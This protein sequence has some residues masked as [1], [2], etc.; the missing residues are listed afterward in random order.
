MVPSKQL[1]LSKRL[2]TEDGISDGG[3]LVNENGVIE[4]LLTTE[5]ANE[6]IS[7]SSGKITVVDGGALA[8]LAGVVDSHVH[9]NEPGR[10]AWEGF[11]T[12]TNAA[13]AGATLKM[14]H[15]RNS[16]PPTTT[17]ENLKTKASA[18]KE[19]IF[20]DVGFW[21]GFPNV[22]REDLEKAFSALEGT[23]SLLAKLKVINRC[24]FSDPEEYSTYLESR[25]PKME[26][27]AISL[28]TSLLEKTD[29][30]GLDL[31]SIS[32]YLSSGPANLC[33]LQHKKGAIKPGVD[34]D[35]VF[36]DSDAYFTL[37]PYI[38]RKLKGVVKKTYL[39]GQLIFD[40]EVVGEPKGELIL[41][42][43]R[44]VTLSGEFEGGVMVDE[45]GVIEAVLSKESVKG[46][47][48]ETLFNF[49]IIDGGNLAL[50]AGVVDSHVHVN[51]PGRTSW[52]GYVTATEAAAAG[53]ITTIIDMPFVHVHIVHVSAEGVVPILERAREKRI[54]AGYIGWRGGITAETCN[55]Y[56]TL[57]SEYIP[58]GHTE[59]KCS[60][61]IRDNANKEKLWQY[62]KEQ[63]LDLIT[64]DHSPSM[65]SLKGVNFL[66]AWG[67]ISS[68]QFDI[69]LFWTEAKARG[70]SLSSVS[71]YLSA[72]PAQL[73]GLQEKK[74]AIRPGLDADLIFFDPDTSFVVTPEIIRYKNKI[75]P[76]MH[77][78]L[79]GKVKQT[80]LRGQLVFADG[81]LIGKPK[82]QLLLSED[83]ID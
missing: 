8:L 66:E 79:N 42:H 64:S 11:R 75:S 15:Y 56:L 29:H 16:I 80:Y 7:D 17:L 58:P 43:L 31:R 52:E 60:P 32:K 51:E 76:Y 6:L 83:I 39:R 5:Q 1:F 72:G 19:N 69:S 35:L 13:A 81:D 63:R 62:I 82:G 73:C 38:G 49:Q 61:P 68:L 23:G 55:H 33:G 27:K 2:V 18:A 25:P 77:R 71:H 74:G 26:M 34:A 78:V 70:Y 40:G 65:P 12:A 9:V 37:T 50:M 57:S 46:L 44:V 41:N 20:V 30:R 59:F 3:V 10:T 22:E 36:F 28:I 4:K 14:F 24:F 54:K 47:L 53:G 48:G 21:G 45:S 67:G